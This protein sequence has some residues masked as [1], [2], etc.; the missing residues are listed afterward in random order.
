MN[1]YSLIQEQLIKLGVKPQ[2]AHKI[3]KELV[4]KSRNN[5]S[6]T[7]DEL[8]NLLKDLA[9]TIDGLSSNQ[10]GKETKSKQYFHAIIQGL[11]ATGLFELFILSKAWL[12]TMFNSIPNK[13]LIEHMEKASILRAKHCDGVS[14]EVSGEVAKL[15]MKIELNRKKLIEAALVSIEVEPSDELI[16]YIN[17]IS[18]CY[19]SAVDKVILKR[20]GL[21]I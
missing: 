12:S 2:L 13:K 6:L 20:M 9:D 8:N 18:Y 4:E 5:P 16:S 1:S 15:S 11:I 21:S 19:V 14:A 17:N 10:C 7:C 3:A